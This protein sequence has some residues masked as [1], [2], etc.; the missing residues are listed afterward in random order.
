[1]I[2]KHSS[3]PLNISF[4]LLSSSRVVFSSHLLFSLVYSSSIISSSPLLFSWK[5]AVF[6]LHVYLFLLL[7]T[8]HTKKDI[9]NC[10]MKWYGSECAEWECLLK[11]GQFSSH[12]RAIHRHETREMRTRRICCRFFKS[13]FSTIENKTSKC[14][15]ILYRWDVKWCF[16]KVQFSITSSI[17]LMSVTQMKRFLVKNQFDRL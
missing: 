9:V 4:H 12:Q 17:T 1:M 15:L 13:C 16:L 10:D 5:L 2:V 6:V 3:H 7:I 8:G 14:L 11:H